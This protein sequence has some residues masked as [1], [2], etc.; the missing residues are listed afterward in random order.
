MKR[1]QDGRNSELQIPVRMLSFASK[2]SSSTCVVCVISCSVVSD[3]LRP[4]GL[5]PTRLLCSQDSPGKPTG[6]DSHFLF[7]E[8]FPTQGFNWCLLHLLQLQED[9]F[10]LSHLGSPALTNVSIKEDSIGSQKFRDIR[11]QAEWT[12]RF[13]EVIFSTLAVFALMW[14]RVP[15]ESNRD[16]PWDLQVDGY[17]TSPCQ[18]QCFG[19]T[20]GGICIQGYSESKW[21]VQN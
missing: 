5:Q 9:S 12:Q 2:R 11:L 7:Q 20:K 17:S 6:A 18:R 10:P 8:I 21:H 15:L 16:H 3:A 4:Y 19:V 14:G 13:K 1:L